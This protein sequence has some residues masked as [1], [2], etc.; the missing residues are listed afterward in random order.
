MAWEKQGQRP[1]AV[2]PPPPPSSPH[3]TDSRYIEEVAES[4]R[5]RDLRQ[6]PP[7]LP[8]NSGVFLIISGSRRMDKLLT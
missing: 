1:P 6:S 8:L 4:Y 2:R 5:L 3:S 7:P